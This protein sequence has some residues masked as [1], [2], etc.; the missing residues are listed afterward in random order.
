MAYSYGPQALATSG[1]SSSPIPVPPVTLGGQP[2]FLRPYGLQLSSL[3]AP[4]H[5]GIPFN[6]LQYQPLTVDTT[7]TYDRI[8]LGVTAN[9]AGLTRTFTYRIGLY[10]DNNGV[11]GSLLNDF[12][13]IVITNAT[14]AGNQLITIN[15]TL[16]ANTK[17]WLALG[18]S[19][20]D[21]TTQPYSSV[22]SLAVL[23]GDFE[24]MR[25]LGSPSAGSSVSS[26]I[27]FIESFGSFSGTLP[28]SYTGAT[29][30]NVHM[31]LISLRRSA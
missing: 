17:Y 10:S 3:I 4:P 25:L 15:K 27:C 8:G 29:I 18:V 21:A 28:A 5:G 2:R 12:G 6:S 30:T 13:T 22:P 24:N 7:S 11:P 26:G 31:P 23:M 20:D 9:V 19:T 1:D 14:A 16:T